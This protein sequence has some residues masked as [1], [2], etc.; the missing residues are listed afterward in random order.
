M[1]SLNRT[2]T[3]ARDG[4]NQKQMQRRE[5]RHASRAKAPVLEVT[6]ITVC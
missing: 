3:Q 1:K 4:T 2:L 5:Q 6:W